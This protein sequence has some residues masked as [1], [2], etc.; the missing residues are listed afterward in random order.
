MV[1]SLRIKKSLLRKHLQKTLSGLGAV[2]RKAKSRKILKRFLRDPGYRKAQNI[3]IY[4]SFGREV[5][6]KS[7]ILRALQDGKKVF[8]PRIRKAGKKINIYRVL[9]L[10][11][12]LKKGAYGIL[13][14][15]PMPARRGKPSQL[16]TVIVPGLGFDRTG[17]RLGRGHGY[18]DRFL[19]RV[20]GAKK[21]ALAFREQM[22]S[23]VPVEK[24]D[25]PVDRIITD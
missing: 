5:D 10:K 9:D 12:D 14:P 2:R 24:H 13:E 17:R 21:I 3:F 19:A 16:D 23:K 25:L 1:S 6:T 15:R 20:R 8:V 4:I 11:K 22:V 7:L 18:F